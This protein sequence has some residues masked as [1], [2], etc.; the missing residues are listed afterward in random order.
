MKRFF[1]DDPE[2]ESITFAKIK[3]SMRE[4]ARTRSHVSAKPI[5]KTSY[6]SSTDVQR[7][8][9]GQAYEE[10]QQKVPAFNPTLVASRRDAAWILSSLTPFYDQHLITDVLHEAHSGL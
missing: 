7:W 5:R 8:L 2:E 4:R 10:E 3:P 6:E 1:E 9:R